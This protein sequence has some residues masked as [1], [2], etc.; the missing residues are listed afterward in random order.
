MARVGRARARLDL[1]NKAGAAADAR[2]VPKGFVKLITR[3]SAN[4]TRWN[5]IYRY[6]AQERQTSIAVEFW[7]LTEGGVPDP[8]VDLNYTGTVAFDGRTKLVVARKF[9][10]LESPM[11]LATYEEAR[12]IQGEAEGGQTALD[13]VNELHAAAKVPAFTGSTA[14]ALDH[15]IKEERRRV[16]FLEGHRMNDVIR[17]NL[18]FPSGRHPFNERFYGNSTCFPLPSVEINNNPNL[19]GS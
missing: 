17:H 14:A 4:N 11:R 10:A 3:E 2:L 1:G 6:N 5:K 9:T 15:L 7:N 13:V 8:R 19:R 16:L 12:L 18:G